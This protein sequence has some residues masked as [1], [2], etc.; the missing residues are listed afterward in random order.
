MIEL[1]IEGQAC[2]ETSCTSHCRKVAE[3]Q[4]Q[5]QKG[6]E[7]GLLFVLF[8]EHNSFSSLFSLVVEN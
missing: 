5:G 6:K 7:I 8:E 3:G 2:G 1:L 4:G